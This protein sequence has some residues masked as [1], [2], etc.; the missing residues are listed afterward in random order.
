VASYPLPHRAQFLGLRAN[1]DF[2][3]AGKSVSPEW[4]QHLTTLS[5]DAARFS[6]QTDSSHGPRLFEQFAE[7]D[8]SL[9]ASDPGSGSVMDISAR[10]SRTVLEGLSNPGPVL[11]SQGLIAALDIGAGAPGDENIIAIDPAKG[12]SRSKW[13]IGKGKGRGMSALVA[14][15]GTT[16]LAVNEWR[17][18]RVILVDLQ[19]LETVREFVTDEMPEGLA[20]IGSCI[21]VAA[22]E[23]R[24]LH[25][26]DAMSTQTTPL[27]SIDYSAHGDR[28]RSVRAVAADP[29]LAGMTLYLRSVYPWDGGDKK[30][31]SSMFRLDILDADLLKACGRG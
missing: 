8:G 5:G 6:V 15:P 2:L 16:L 26:F 29:S 9:F 7:L 25:L 17:A 21:A 19:T 13:P 11:A 22:T 20:V 23:A 31:Q 10:P 24:K 28:L 12:T 18:N 30:T 1:G 3:A 27:A 14:I 4:A